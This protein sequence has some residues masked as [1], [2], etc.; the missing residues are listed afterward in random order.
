MEWW[1]IAAIIICT[2]ALVFSIYAAV[3]VGARSEKHDENKD[4][5]QDK[6]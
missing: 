2:V 6:T 1:R 5:P 4:D 3:V